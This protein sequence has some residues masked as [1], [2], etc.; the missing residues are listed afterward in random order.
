MTVYVNMDDKPVKDRISPPQG[1]VELNEIHYAFEPRDEQRAI[2]TVIFSVQKFFF[3]SLSRQ[4][5]IFYR[6]NLLSILTYGQNLN[7]G[8]HG[9]IRIVHWH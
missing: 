1:I 9:E 6:R 5:N 2:M 3:S 8:I 7:G 4:S